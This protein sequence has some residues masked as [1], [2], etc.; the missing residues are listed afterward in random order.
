MESKA[1]VKST[2]NIV[3]CR[4]FARTPSTILRIVNICEVEDLFHRIFD[5]D[6]NQGS[7]SPSL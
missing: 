4:F 2:N 1:I 5:Q 7:Y 3:A 6:G